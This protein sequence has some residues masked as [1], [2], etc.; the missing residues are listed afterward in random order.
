[1]DGLRVLAQADARETGYLVIPSW[2]GTAY[3]RHA[4]YDL[5][6]GRIRYF[7]QVEPDGRYGRYRLDDLHSP[8]CIARRRFDAELSGLPMPAGYCVAKTVV[9]VADSRYAVEG[10][11]V[12]RDRVPA[13]ITVSDRQ[14]GAV[15]AEYRRPRLAWLRGKSACLREAL[16]SPGHPLWNIGSFVFPDGRGEVFGPADLERVRRERTQGTARSDLL[17]PVA[18]TVRRLVESG[19]RLAPGCALPG[20]MGETE[21]HVVELERGP[22]DV[23]ARLDAESDKAGFVILDVYVPDKAVV[24]LARARGPTVWHIHESSRSSIVAVLVRGYHGQAVV[25]LTQYSRILMSTQL[26]NPFTNCTEQALRDIEHRVT[27]QYGITRTQRQ[28]IGASPA[29]VRYGLGAEMPDGA[30]LFHYEYALSDFEVREPDGN[31][32]P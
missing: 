21:V 6:L 26:H 25:G 32:S 16:K 28:E 22:L 30:E 23:A 18:W 14:T 11:P 2:T 15:L 31:P 12:E 10:Y 20:W 1:M 13:R 8:D 4:V 9:P 24:I 5:V 7:E 27:R 17:P 19:K 3:F 29:V